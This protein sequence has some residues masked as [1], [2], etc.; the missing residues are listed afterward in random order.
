MGQVEVRRRLVQQEDFRVLREGTR[1]M[2][3]LSL[4]PGEFRHESIGEVLRF[5]RAHGEI[6]GFLIGAGFRRESTQVR[7]SSHRHDLA[8]RECEVDA[9]VLMHHRRAQRDLT[10]RQRAERCTAEP[11]L[12]CRWWQHTQQHAQQGRLAAV[13]RADQ[14]NKL[15]CTDGEGNALQN[16]PPGVSKGDDV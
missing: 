5:R 2:Y 9:R 4:S 12:A 13:I 14:A 8:R 6:N 10:A 3:P 7:R 11:H 15:S 16:G 1:K